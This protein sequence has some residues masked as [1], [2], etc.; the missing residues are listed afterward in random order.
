MLPHSEVKMR[1]Y[2]IEDIPQITK[3]VKKHLPELPH[4]KNITVAEDRLAYLLR[5]NIDRDSYFRCWVL[6]NEL[7]EIVGGSAGYLVPGMVTWD[8]IANDVF[9]FVFP[10]YRT[11]ARANM[12]VKA[13]KDWALARGAVLITVSV[14]SGYEPTKYD[15]FIRRLGFVQSGALYHLRMDENFVKD[16]LEAL[17]GN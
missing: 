1:P 5:H 10:E 12:L 14:Q 11:L 7:G 8:L 13:Y 2:R 6:E 9:L 17:K 15:I 3:A 4:Y 16:K